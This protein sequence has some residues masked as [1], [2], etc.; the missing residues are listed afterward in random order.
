MESWSLY[1]QNTP[2]TPSSTWLCPQNNAPASDW[3]HPNNNT[4]ERERNENTALATPTRYVMEYNDVNQNSSSGSYYN[5]YAQEMERLCENSFLKLGNPEDLLNN[6]LTSWLNNETVVPVT[7][8]ASN[9]VNNSNSPTPSLVT[10][11]DQD[12]LYNNSTY[13]T[14]NQDIYYKINVNNRRSRLRLLHLQI[15]HPL[16]HLKNNSKKFVIL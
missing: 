16:F 2:S 14:K 12:Q 6:N 10:D 8:T 11:D 1:T 7:T 5:P 13:I 4:T 3:L 15:H 9:I